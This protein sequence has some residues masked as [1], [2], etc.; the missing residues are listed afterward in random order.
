[1]SCVWTTGVDLQMFD[2]RKRATGTDGLKL[3]RSS[4]V[5][6]RL[7]SRKCKGSGLLSVSVRGRIR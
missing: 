1:M 6:R 4:L 7:K 2:T 5:R 3:F